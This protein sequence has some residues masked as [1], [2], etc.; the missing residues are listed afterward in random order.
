[1]ENILQ[2]IAI[3]QTKLRREEKFTDKKSLS[4]STLQTDYINLD[5][6]SGFGRDNERANYVQTKCNF[7]GGVN[8]S[9]EKYFKSIR[10]K[11]KKLVRLAIET[12]DKQNRC[13][14][15]VLDVDMKTT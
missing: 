1:M 12:T 13:L 8:H 11:K 10:Q 7:C 6:S 9:E 5:S 14:G 2:K 3:H 4:I 15:K